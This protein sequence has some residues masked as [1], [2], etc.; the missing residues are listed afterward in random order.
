MR[1]SVPN[2]WL[3]AKKINAPAVLAFPF[4][5]CGPSIY[6]RL[7]S[8]LSREWGVELYAIRPP[9]IEARFTE[10]RPQSHAEY[11]RDLASEMATTVNGKYSIFGHCGAIPY[12]VETLRAIELCHGRELLP[13][14]VVFSGWGPPHKGLYGAL[15]F[16]D[17]QQITYDNEVRRVAHSTGIDLIDE[18]VEIYAEQLEFDVRQQRAYVFDT[19]K[20]ESLEICVVGWSD[21][22]VVPSDI[23]VSDEWRDSFPNASIEYTVLTGGHFTFAEAPEELCRVICLNLI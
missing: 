6:H 14:R 17:L 11:A 21:D 9:G 2:S 4:A 15:N 22:E 7:A 12:V 16:A 3:S 13:H 19:I 5:G 20:A 10:P 18:F 1:V 8:Q 23:V